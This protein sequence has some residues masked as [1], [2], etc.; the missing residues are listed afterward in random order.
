M[1]GRHGARLGGRGPVETSLGVALAGGHGGLGAE[2]EE[3]EGERGA[4][5]FGCALFG[6]LLDVEGGMMMRKARRWS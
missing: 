6:L 1:F 3:V 2:E 4:L 5:C